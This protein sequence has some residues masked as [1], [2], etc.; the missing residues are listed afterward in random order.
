[1]P[2]AIGVSQ[3]TQLAAQRTELE[4]ATGVLNGLEPGLSVRFVFGAAGG[5][6]D[7][8]MSGHTLALESTG[9]VMKAH[10]RWNLPDAILH[11][12]VPYIVSLDGASVE[13]VADG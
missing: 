11:P 8:I 5:N 6:G 4:G 3:K 2:V 9:G 12:N 13:V 7:L 1:M 10:C